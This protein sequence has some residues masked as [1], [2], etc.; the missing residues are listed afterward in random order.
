VD[1]SFAITDVRGEPR[2]RAAVNLDTL[3]VAGVR[4]R[5]AGAE[6]TV[7]D[8]RHAG[9]H[10]L[11][12][13]ETGERL[14]TRG[15]WRM[16]EH[17][18]GAPIGA[19]AP[20]SGA[21]SS[22][23]TLLLARA[24]GDGFAQGDGLLPA[25][26][27]PRDVMERHHI[28]ELD[29]LTL[30]LDSTSGYAL[31]RGPARI[32]LH[33]A[34]AQIDSLELRHSVR[35]WARVNGGITDTGSVELA[36][37]AESL[38]L[39][40]LS[41]LAQAT[42]PA[43]GLLSLDARVGGT[44][45][46]PSMRLAGTL[47]S[48]AVASAR[49]ERI[50]VVAAY[51]STRLSA[52]LDLYRGGRRALQA[53]ASLPVDLALRPVGERLLQNDSLSGS[54]H[55]DSV[56]LAVI[57]AFSDQVRDTRGALEANV[58]LGGTW[59]SPV[60]TGHFG[61]T[62]GEMSLVNAGT[63]LRDMFADVTLNGD[64]LAIRRF[65]ARS[66]GGRTRALP[67]DTLALTGF[68][69]F[70]ALKNFDDFSQ[71]RMGLRLFA[72]NA[73]LIDRPRVATLA[74]TTTSPLTLSGPYD[75]AVLR[76]AVRVEEGVIA[77]PELLEKQVIDP[78]DPELLQLVDTSLY[79]NRTLLSKYARDTADAKY[80]FV[81]Y[82]SAENVTLAIGDNVWLRSA[83]ANIKLG[84]TLNVRRGRSSRADVAPQLALD[85]TL[86]TVR[87]NYRLN[88]GPVQPSFEVERGTLKFF[89]DPDLNPTLDI[90]ALH[91]VR[92]PRQAAASN[93]PDV[94][95]R[96]RI[97]GT[98]AQ[99]SLSLS[100]ADEPPIP[101]TDLLSYLITGEPSLQLGESGGRGGEIGSI[102]LR[103]GS[104]YLSSFAESRLGFFD[105]VQL[106]TAG[107]E[108]GQIFS[109]GQFRNARLGL[110]KQIGNRTFISLNTGICPLLSSPGG[111]A[112]TDQQQLGERIRSQLGGKLEHRFN[113]GF[114]AEIGLEPGANSVTCTSNGAQRQ[115]L[116]P[117]PS[118]VGFDLFRQWSF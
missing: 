8:A 19:A 98:L 61:V 118:Q 97:E 18:V 103:T 57:E 70:P 7:Q 40:D 48:V 16:A 85:G 101:T 94:R 32:T 22:S 12:A 42:S 30:T 68:V 14:E 17:A 3:T 35:G 64:S 53:T 26:P 108:G 45:D 73:V 80:D 77:I 51:D 49:V 75:G 54:V 84:G 50:G 91:T 116:N 69:T 4:L 83:E 88:L 27:A 93:R 52:N 62:G 86:E 9:F 41:R 102:I 107:S 43:T 67:G 13:S 58:A 100:S 87:G 104:S 38:S 106:Q 112:S 60:L 117:T 79:V 56:G 24:A 81:K 63:R 31:A 15:R 29:S 55:T 111:T 25:P 74:F 65:V 47:D 20:A 66:V 59:A 109:S 33:E 6:V 5:H 39:G 82:L 28:V 46:R 76:G 37:V 34:G 114:S 115:L 99:P 71:V 10:V 113:S 1:G 11:V 92:Q 78:S 36:V 90:S 44:R 96:V 23:G 95:V 105:V 2:G 110:G 21:T 72:R 89:G